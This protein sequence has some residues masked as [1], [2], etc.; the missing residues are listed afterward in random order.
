MPR[1]GEARRFAVTGEQRRRPH[2]VDTIRIAIRQVAFDAIASTVALGM[3]LLAAP[4]CAGSRIGAGFHGGGFPA[5]HRFGGRARVFFGGYLCGYNCGLGFYNPGYGYGYGY[6]NG[7][8]NGYG[9]FNGKGYFNGYG[10]DIGYGYGNGAANAA[11]ISNGLNGG[12]VPDPV[13]ADIPP[14]IIPTNCWVRRP[15]YDPSGAYF[16]QVLVNLCRPSGSV[17]VTGLKAR[18]K[19]PDTGAGAPPVYQPG[20]PQLPQ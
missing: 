9:Y 4:A 13:G 17:T 7:Y 14:L 16:G 18:P 8:F 5:F 2:I 20:S 1:S 11:S 12:Y 19:T 10:N 3:V 6:G 15:A